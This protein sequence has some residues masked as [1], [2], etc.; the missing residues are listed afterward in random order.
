MIKTIQSDE[1]FNTPF[2]SHKS[3]EISSDDSIVTVED[4]FFVSSSYNF[5][6]SGSSYEH[7]FPVEPQN[8]NGTYKRLVYNV[9]KNAYYTNNVAQAFGLETMDADKV[10]KILQSSLVRFIIPRTYFGEK[11]QPDSVVINDYSKDK[12]Y[13]ILDDQYGNLYVAGTHFIN[14]NEVT[15]SL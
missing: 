10:I 3:W 5:Y 12:N 2:I 13:V 1:T 8:S 11:I 4:G 14:Y 15:S 7:G 6:D 9:V